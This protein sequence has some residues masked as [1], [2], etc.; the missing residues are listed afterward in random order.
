MDKVVVG[1]LFP[2]KVSGWFAYSIVDMLRFDAANNQ[3]FLGEGGF[4]CLS[5]GPRV[6]EARNQLIDEFAKSYPDADW[7]FMVD[8]DMTF[9]PDI[10]EMLLAAADPQERPVVGALA[11]A[12]SGDNGGPFPTIYK[13]IEV[14]DGGVLI[15]RVLDYPE[16]ALV[17]V[18]ATG[19]A[20]LLIHR[21]VL[22][23]MAQPF[24]K[25]FGT[26]KDGRPN[27]YPWFA[28]G[29]LDAYNKP[30]GEDV[31]FCRRCRHLGIPVH[32]LTAAK[33]GHVKSYKLDEQYFRQHRDDAEA[34]IGSYRRNE[35]APLNRAQRRAEAR[36]KGADA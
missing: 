3:R 9:E 11:F 26:L 16:D 19:A 33:M 35:P 30:L 31:A 2:D 28:E 22:A 29:L 1:W 23:S 32:V 15:D 6:A 20:G 12:A 25:G 4:M 17:K 21:G 24:P 14:E 18:G 5:S 27:P 8:S 34:A 13:E 10:V 36:K 7:L